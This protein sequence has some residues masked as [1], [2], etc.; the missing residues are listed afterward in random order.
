M[1]NLPPEELRFRH[2]SGELVEI[3]HRSLAVARLQ[4]YS[5]NGPPGQE[6]VKNVWISRETL[7][8]MEKFLWRV[9]K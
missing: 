6:T 4:T 1:S 9:E 8:R 2:E 3:G 7:E 5:F